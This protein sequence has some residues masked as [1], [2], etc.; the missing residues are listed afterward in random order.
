M[1]IIPSIRQETYLFPVKQP[2]RELFYDLD[3]ELVS[4]M[5]EWVAAQKIP[6]SAVAVLRLSQFIES[7]RDWDHQFAYISTVD[8]L[9]TLDDFRRFEAFELNACTPQDWKE[10]GLVGIFYRWVRANW[11]VNLPVLPMTD[12]CRDDSDSD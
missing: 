5:A 6:A 7:E 4:P 1:S 10:L 2:V 3:P 9:P 8:K 11:P 12:G